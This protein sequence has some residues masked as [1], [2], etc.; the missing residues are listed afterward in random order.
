MLV[1]IALRIIQ[2]AV[3]YEGVK[4]WTARLQPESRSSGGLR[5]DWGVQ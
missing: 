4:F 2:E 5:L 3:T 1:S